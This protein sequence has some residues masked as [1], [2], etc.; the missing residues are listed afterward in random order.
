MGI[1]V[2]PPLGAVNNAVTNTGAQ[3]SALVFH[4]ERLLGHVV[5]VNLPF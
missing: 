5:V 4:G 2:V 1:R 3:L